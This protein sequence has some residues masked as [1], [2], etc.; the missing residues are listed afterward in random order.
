M[1][2][3]E[4][5]LDEL[6][7][8]LTGPIAANAAFDGW[9]DRALAT[10]AQSIGVPFERAKLVFPGGAVDMID[11]WFAEVEAGMTAAVPP[12]RLA[13]LKIRER[14]RDLILA[15]LTL[16]QPHRESLRRALAVLAL[17]G[18]LA[19]ATR[20][21][22]RAADRIWRAAGDEATDFNHY[23]KRAILGAIYAATILVWIDDGSEGEIETRQF[24]DR[25]IA[26]IMR[27]EQTKA[28]L[29]PDPDA[30]FSPIRFFGRLRYPAI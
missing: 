26:G 23:S 29:K 12:D 15:R 27:F 7:V 2:P 21:G 1:K 22:W 3:N 5:T 18:N 30:Y 10:A 25:R 24:L 9:G 6:R 4:M 11:C 16:M 8:V 20:L 19:R 28:R 17:P 14:I 13:G